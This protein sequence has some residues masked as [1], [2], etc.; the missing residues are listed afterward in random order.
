MRIYAIAD[1]HGKKE[2]IETIYAV[3]EKF[4]PDLVV[5]AGDLSHFFNWRTSLAQLDSLPVPV[6]AVR[7]N[8]DF[9]RTEPHIAQAGNLDLLTHTPREINGFSFV[10]SGGTFLLPF[11]SRICLNEK[12]RLASLPSPMDMDTILVVHPPPKGICDRV[13]GKI[14]AGSKNLALF[15]EQA[16]PGLVLCGHVHEQPGKAML[17]N[18]LVVNCSMS[19]SGAGAVIDLEKNSPPRVNLL[20]PDAVRC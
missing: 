15:I 11:A 19:R 9:R 7:G 14:S 12:K 1:I 13:G 20:H 16:S 6:L 8:T 17:G 4:S 18:S 10:G 3:L 5:A 2:H